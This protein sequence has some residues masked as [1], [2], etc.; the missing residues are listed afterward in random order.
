MFWKA[1]SMSLFFLA[2]VKTSLPDTKISSTILGSIIRYTRPAITAFPTWKHFGFV[3]AEALVVFE[4]L[5][6]INCEFYI[7]AAHDV[8]D[9]EGLEL[10]VVPQFLRFT[11]DCRTEGF[12]WMMRAYFRA[13]MRLSFSVLAP[14]HTILPEAKTRAVV[15]G[16]RS[17]MTTAAKRLG[18]YSAFLAWRAMSLRLSGQSR[19]TVDTMFLD[20]QP[21]PKR[22]PRNS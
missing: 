1:W 12:T 3:A 7:R 15:L 19:L 6:Q 18:L 8:L 11:G 5:V 22:R 4:H 13:A 20:Y 14:V 17:R 2:P 9:L 16:L 21:V 10:D